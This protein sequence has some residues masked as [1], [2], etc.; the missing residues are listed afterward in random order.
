MKPTLAQINT[1]G[2]I[3]TS[4][5]STRNKS[6]CLCE[7]RVPMRLEF[8]YFLRFSA[9]LYHLALFV[10]ILSVLFFTRQE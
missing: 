5:S 7:K 8:L 9:V 4:R 10:F 3:L 2:L 1:E 6:T